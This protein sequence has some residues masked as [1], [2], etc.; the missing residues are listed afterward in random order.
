MC[1]CVC[2]CASCVRACV[3]VVCVYM[4]VCGVLLPSPSLPSFLTPRSYL[5]LTLPLFLPPSLS[6]PL[7]PSHS[8][9]PSLSL[10]PILHKGVHKEPPYG[11]QALEDELA[12]LR[13][14][15]STL[16][17]DLPPGVLC[18][19][20]GKR[21]SLHHSTWTF[22]C[23]HITFISLLKCNCSMSS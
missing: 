7:R 1:V 22:K 20:F 19:P 18:V 13:E 23:P 11:Q 9:T 12:S 14:G 17:V 2:V 21:F 10:P 8:L 6:T 15:E 4:C 16:L 5:P 3:R